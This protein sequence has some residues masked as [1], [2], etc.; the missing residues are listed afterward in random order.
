ML[1]RFKKVQQIGVHSIRMRGCET[2][3]QAGVRSGAVPTLNLKA[4]TS[5]VLMRPDVAVSNDTEFFAQQ[6]Y[7]LPLKLDAVAVPLPWIWEL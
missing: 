1:N 3:R 2:M 5:A 4:N 6:W 7:Q